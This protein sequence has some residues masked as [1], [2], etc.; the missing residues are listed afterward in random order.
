MSRSL[1][2]VHYQLGWKQIP[3]ERREEEG[4][5][6]GGERRKERLRVVKGGGR[7][8]EDGRREHSRG[9][10]PHEQVVEQE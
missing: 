10:S 7:G 3:E 6:E 2:V 1:R 9:K 4:E 8:G 5:G